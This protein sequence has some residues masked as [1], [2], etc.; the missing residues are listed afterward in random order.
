MVS[1]SGT[2]LMALRPDGLTRPTSFR[3]TAT[4]SMSDMPL[5]IEMMHW[6]IASATECRMRLGGGAE[7]GEFAERLLAVFDEGGAERPR[8]AQFA[9][10]QADAGVLA[11]RQIGHAG[12]CGVEQFRDRAFMHGGILPDVE[13]GK[14]EAEAIHGAAQTAASRPRAITPELLAISERSSTS[15]SALNSLTL[16]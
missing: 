4:S 1:N 6:G 3:S 11:Q 16:A 14:M 10:Q 2:M 9:E 15:R 7:Q 12:N 13:P 5:H 8:A